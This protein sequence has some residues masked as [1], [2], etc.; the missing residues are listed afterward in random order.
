M[1]NDIPW[2]YILGKKKQE[3]RDKGENWDGSWWMFARYIEAEECGTV[4]MTGS[5]QLIGPDYESSQGIQYSKLEHHGEVNAQPSF[6][7]PVLGSGNV[8]VLTHVSAFHK[9]PVVLCQPSSQA[10]KASFLSGLRPEQG[11]AYVGYEV[12]GG[13]DLNPTSLHSTT[14]RLATPASA[15]K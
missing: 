5:K 7:T 1:V 3:S 15:A 6:L 10:L 9:D 8:H 2:E 13:D 11:T 14:P 4:V 12:G